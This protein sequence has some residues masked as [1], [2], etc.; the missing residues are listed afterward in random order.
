MTDLI[1]M[2]LGLI[3]EKLGNLDDKVESGLQQVDWQL[4]QIENGLEYRLKQIVDRLRLVIPDEKQ[5][6]LS[7]MIDEELAE[8][9]R[10]L[11]KRRE[12]R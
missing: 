2:E 1:E 7:D 5:G 12:M 6:E 10:E 4:K 3:R 8:L 11:E 9:T